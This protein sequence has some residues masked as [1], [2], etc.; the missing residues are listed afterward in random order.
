M[1]KN[2]SKFQI[3]S[4]Q[5][6]L[7]GS[8]FEVKPP[9]SARGIM[10]VRIVT[11]GFQAALNPKG[12]EEDSIPSI[13]GADVM[14]QFDM[15]KDFALEKLA[16][17]ADAFDAMVEADIPMKDITMAGRYAAYYWVFDEETADHALEDELRKRNG[18]PTGPTDTE[19]PKP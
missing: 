10:L 3:G 19:L 7:G 2:L 4:L 12:L 5:L 11:M 16:L 17:G 9:S 1:A 13:L 18:Q 8:T 6:E 15:E 14:A